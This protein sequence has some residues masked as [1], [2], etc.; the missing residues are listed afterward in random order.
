MLINPPL[1]VIVTRN[2]TQNIP[3]SYPA[4]NYL[5]LGYANV[6]FTYPAVD[7][8]SFPFTKL[9]TAD[10]GPFVTDAICGGELFPG[11]VAVSS[12]TPSA[13]NL[14]GAAPNP[15]NPTTAISF[16]LQASSHVS[17]KV[18]DT[19]GR[20]VATLIDGMREAG[21]HQAIFDGSKLASGTYIYRL[22]AGNQTATGKME[23]VK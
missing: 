5:Y 4:G 14:I 16:K 23:L 19:A 3:S 22:Q 13:F 12:Q 9:A 8:S 6:T 17:L 7:S 10:G 11:E 21:T 20:L 18:Y 2:R 1:N 15:F